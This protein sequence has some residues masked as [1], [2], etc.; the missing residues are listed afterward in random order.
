[1]GLE[2]SHVGMKDRRM[3]IIMDN[4]DHSPILHPYPILSESTGYYERLS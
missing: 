1:M 4:S 3:R 2:E